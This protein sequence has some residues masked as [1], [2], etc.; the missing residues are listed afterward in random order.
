MGRVAT[1]AT[2]VL[3]VLLDNEVGWCLQN[4]VCAAKRE[5]R[6]GDWIGGTGI[7]LHVTAWSG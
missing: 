2:M 3:L 4:L 5:T 7:S 1:K 6:T